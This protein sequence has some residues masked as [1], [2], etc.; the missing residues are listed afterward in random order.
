MRSKDCVDS[1]DLEV[2]DLF[3][4]PNQSGDIEFIETGV[5]DKMVQDS[6]SD[7]A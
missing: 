6:A 4:R 3:E 7:V 5:F 1:E 2:L